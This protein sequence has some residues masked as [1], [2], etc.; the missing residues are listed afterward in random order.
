MSA[1]QRQQRSIIGGIIVF[2]VGLIFVT[3]SESIRLPNQYQTFLEIPYANNGAYAL[4]VVLKTF[5]VIM[6]LAS[7]SVGVL[8]VAAGAIISYR[9]L[10]KNPNLLTQK[11][12]FFGTPNSQTVNAPTTAQASQTKIAC[13]SCN[14]EKP[15]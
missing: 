2:F 14:P 15:H 8:A 9:G 11:T 7:L 12:I 5:S 6:G 4:D 10:H 3:Y 13:Y 1:T